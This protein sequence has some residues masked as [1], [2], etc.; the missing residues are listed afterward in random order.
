MLSFIAGMVLPSWSQFGKVWG[1]L[2]SGGLL[3]CHFHFIGK[4][5]EVQRSYLE[6]GDKKMNKEAKSVEITQVCRADL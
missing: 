4:N 5:D 2:R 3:H 1:L 6:G